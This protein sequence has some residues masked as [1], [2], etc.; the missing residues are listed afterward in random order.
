LIFCFSS[1][2]QQIFY[3]GKDPGN[4]GTTSILPILHIIFKRQVRET[5][6]KISIKKALN[7]LLHTL[8]SPFTNHFKKTLNFTSFRQRRTLKFKFSF[9]L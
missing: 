3:N 9:K 2:R 5:Y 8:I 4:F 7:L 1:I 6:V